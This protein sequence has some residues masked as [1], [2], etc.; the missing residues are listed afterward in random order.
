[1]A[2][3]KYVKVPTAEKAF[4]NNENLRSI[5]D[6]A[7][8][9]RGSAN[10]NFRDAF[11]RDKPIS[12]EDVGYTEMNRVVVQETGSKTVPVDITN[13]LKNRMTRS[14]GDIE[15]FRD[16]KAAGLSA[17]EV[18]PRA[19]KTQVGIVI[20]GGNIDV[21]NVGTISVKT[22]SKDVLGLVRV[23]NNLNVTDGVISLATASKSTLGG[24]I[25]GDNID[26]DGSGRI[27]LQKASTSAYGIVK[28]GT[29][30]NVS[31]DSVI[32]VPVATGNSLGV[33]RTG[34]NITNTNGIISIPIAT[35]GTL[36]VVK[37]GANITISADGSINAA[38]SYIHPPT[39]PGDMIT[40]DP[41]HRWTTDAEKGKWNSML[42][43]SGGAMSGTI[44]LKNASNSWIGGRDDACLTT[45]VNTDAYTAGL[46]F[47]GA[48]WTFSV[49]SLGNN[50]AGIFVY[51]NSRSDN[52]YDANL[53]IDRSGTTYASGAIN[54]GGDVT[55][56]SDSRL[57]TNVHTIESALGIVSQLRGV[58]F[59][60]KKDNSKSLGLIAQEVKEVIPDAVTYS[61]DTGHYGVK[62]GNL[63][64]LLINAINELQ[65]KISN[66]ENR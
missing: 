21:D 41:N 1:M 9:V 3:E 23:G 32:S 53:Y 35:N 22:A 30:I 24:I 13:S 17:V 50:R 45:T 29:N 52:G 10:V 15:L 42:P 59:N 66:L 55:A 40:E 20:V 51:S 44:T 60:W 37:A 46:N 7:I 25:V 57:K 34:A 38:N 39:H 62:Y 14:L 28:I 64:G 63:V 16:I 6:E 11:G 26:V 61:K 56:M 54:A 65:E 49:G 33:V 43:L 5:P 19:S 27:S 12:K 31:A 36:G 4:Y 8:V 47:R 58:T 18:I 2:N 48:E